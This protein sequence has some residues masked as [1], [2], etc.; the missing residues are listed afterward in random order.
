MYLINLQ[1]TT[2]SVTAG[3]TT[4]LVD[5]ATS[6]QLYFRKLDVVSCL[7]SKVLPHANHDKKT[8]RVGIQEVFI[9]NPEA[10]N[11]KPNLR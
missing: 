10:K 9:P 7:S 2:I 11:Q 5:L 1:L 8:P 3:I 4:L 6:V